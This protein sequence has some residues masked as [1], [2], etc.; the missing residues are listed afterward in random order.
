MSYHLCA[1]PER[2]QEFRMSEHDLS[3]IKPARTSTDRAARREDRARRIRRRDAVYAN[4]LRY[5]L[6]EAGTLRHYV[7]TSA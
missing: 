2:N 1:G 5:A 6:A 7:R 4:E 3:K